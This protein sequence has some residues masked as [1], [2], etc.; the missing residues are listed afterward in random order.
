MCAR[1]SCRRRCNDVM[2]YKVVCRPRTSRGFWSRAFKGRTQR[3]SFLHRCFPRCADV[4][5]NAVARK[6]ACDEMSPPHIFDMKQATN[7]PNELSAKQGS[8][9]VPVRLR[10]KLALTSSRQQLPSDEYLC[11]KCLGHGGQRSATIG[12]V[13]SDWCEVSHVKTHTC[14]K[15]VTQRTTIMCKYTKTIKYFLNASVRNG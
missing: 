15:P 3:D 1:V 14:T 10:L 9:S 8:G 11:K 12:C 6:D 13:I 5:L 2:R 4:P 7:I